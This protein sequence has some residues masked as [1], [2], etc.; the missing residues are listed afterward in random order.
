MAKKSVEPE[1]ETFNELFPTIQTA[2]TM[3]VQPLATQAFSCG[4]ITREQ[5]NTCTHMMYTPDQQAS[6]FLKVIGQQIDANPAA[7]LGSL[8]N[9]LDSD[10]VYDYLVKKIGTYIWRAWR[11]SILG[12]AIRNCGID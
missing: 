10:A 8:R 5:L 9:I 12:G 6:Q 2:I 4:L 11:Y 1:V 3:G 7:A